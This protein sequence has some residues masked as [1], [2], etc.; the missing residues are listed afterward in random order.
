MQLS[1]RRFQGDTGERFAILVDEFGM[2]LYHHALYATAVLRGASLSV[3]TIN[4]AL[5]AI[6]M[7]C[8]WG[9]YYGLSLES[10]FK[11]GALLEP[12]EKR[13]GRL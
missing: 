5:G 6:K 8:A 11:Q 2:P 10:R 12:H 4:N 1:I 3:N 7:V 13:F 9:S